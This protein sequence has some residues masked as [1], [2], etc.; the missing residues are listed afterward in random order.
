LTSRSSS[1]ASLTE[2]AYYSSGPLRQPARTRAAWTRKAFELALKAPK[3]RQLL[4]YQ[5]VDPAESLTWRT[6][7]ISNRSSRHP[8]YDA[9]RGFADAR[10]KRLTLPRPP[11]AL[12]AAPA[13]PPAG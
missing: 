1:S 13:A 11:F 5:L 7:L 10:R 8:A 2:F 4:Y 9:L 6:G 3:V 12:P